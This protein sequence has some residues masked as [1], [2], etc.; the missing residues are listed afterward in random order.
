VLFRYITTDN[1]TS[2]NII[3][4]NI[5]TANIKNQSITDDEII[6]V[7]EQDYLHL[8]WVDAVEFLYQTNY[9]RLPRTPEHK[10]K[11]SQKLKLIAKTTILITN[12]VENRRILRTDSIPTSY[13][14]GFSR[15]IKVSKLN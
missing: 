9:K 1:I 12:G 13:R 8:P 5:T 6:Y 15:G 11:L 10:L 4:S 7:L 14:Q 3:T 2:A